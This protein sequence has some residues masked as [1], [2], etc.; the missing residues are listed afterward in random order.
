MP[1]LDPGVT[2]DQAI[3][4]AVIDT[5]RIVAIL[6]AAPTRVIASEAKQSIS[7]RMEQLDCFV[8]TRLAKTDTPS[9]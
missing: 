8:A 2:G 5:G 7:P 3:T 6:F 1:G 9:C 4:S